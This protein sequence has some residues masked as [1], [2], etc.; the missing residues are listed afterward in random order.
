MVLISR[1]WK[2]QN[3]DKAFKTLVADQIILLDTVKAQ[4][5]VSTLGPKTLEEFCQEADIQSSQLLAIA[6]DLD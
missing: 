3:K 2:Y 4:G 1:L 6:K 5:V